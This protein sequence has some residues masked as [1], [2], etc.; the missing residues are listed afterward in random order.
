MTFAQ[1]RN[2]LTTHISE[3]IPLVNRRMTVHRPVPAWEFK[4]T[5]VEGEMVMQ[6]S[7][8]RGSWNTMQIIHHHQVTFSY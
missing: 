7:V 2:R 1:R 6:H 5:P 8:T 3:R 4:T